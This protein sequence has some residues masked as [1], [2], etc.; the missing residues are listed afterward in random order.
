MMIMMCLCVCVNERV[1]A[2]MH[3]S[4]YIAAQGIE[5]HERRHMCMCFV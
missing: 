5:H 2:S 1:S 3:G 4:V